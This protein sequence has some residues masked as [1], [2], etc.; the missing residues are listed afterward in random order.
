M[1][2]SRRVCDKGQLSES[3]RKLEKTVFLGSHDGT[4]VPH[5]YQ[6]FGGANNANNPA[7]TL[8]KPLLWAAL[9]EDMVGCL[10]LHQNDRIGLEH[11]K[12]RKLPAGVNP[13]IKNELVVTQMNDQCI[14]NEH[15][16]QQQ[17]QQPQQQQQQQ[18]QPQQQNH[19]VQCPHQGGGGGANNVGM[20][21]P[22]MMQVLLHMQQEMFLTN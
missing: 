12:I 4:I 8:A 21:N 18:Q 7:L 16:Q 11:R 5:T 13:I 10:D 19:Q 14:I 15:G 3:G 9:S 6:F 1:S 2:C 17:Q 22:Q 20:C